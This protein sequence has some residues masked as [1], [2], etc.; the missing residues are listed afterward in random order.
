MRMRYGT[1][2]VAKQ[3]LSRE[4]TKV[5]RAYVSGLQGRIRR[6]IATLGFACE[7][8]HEVRLAQIGDDEPDFEKVVLHVLC[9]EAFREGY[10]NCAHNEAWGRDPDPFGSEIRALIGLDLLDLDEWDAWLVQMRAR[11]AAV[12]SSVANAQGGPLYGAVPLEKPAKALQEPNLEEQRRI[13][14]V[15]LGITENLLAA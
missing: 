10:P 4:L 12:D 7:C 6:K 15:L 3:E 1:D 13:G 8:E 2:G 9:P 14:G 11:I 5:E